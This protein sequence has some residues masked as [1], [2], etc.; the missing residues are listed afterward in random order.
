MVREFM[1]KSFSVIGIACF[2]IS[3]SFAEFRIWEDKAGKVWEGEFVTMNAGKVVIQDR[4]G[5]KQEYSPDELSE[6]DVSYL[7]EI[8]PPRLSLDVSKSSDSS[9]SGKAESIICRA[10]IKKANTRSYKG[11]LTAVL[12]IIAEEM[13]TGAF[14]KAGASKEFTFT[15]PEKHGVPVEFETSSIKLAKSSA[16]SGRVYAGY[17]LVVWDRFG[18]PIAVKSNRDSFLERAARIAR[19]HNG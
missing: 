10:S 6:N 14:S 11:E 3:A 12:V 5:K 17:V 4:D 2:L 7:E 16:K 9:T 8:I 13:R 1:Y 15:L 18:N 19:P